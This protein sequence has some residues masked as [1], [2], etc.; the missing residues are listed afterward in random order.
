MYI[1]HS[2]IK[3]CNIKSFD[4][5]ILYKFI[6]LTSNNHCLTIEDYQ[7]HNKH[8]TNLKMPSKRTLLLTLWMLEI[9]LKIDYIVV[10]FLKPLNSACF[11]I[12]NDGLSS[13]QVGSQA[14]HRVTWRL[15]WIQ[16]VWISINGVPAQKGLIIFLK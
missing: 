15:A 13:K 1:T 14:G 8:L 2:L 6:F 3:W 7:P 9:F 11:F 16:P 5:L 4:M 12:G 10:C